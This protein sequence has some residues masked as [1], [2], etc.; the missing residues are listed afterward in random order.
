MDSRNEIDS[1]LGLPAH[2]IWSYLSGGW[3]PFV[4]DV[5]HGLFAF[6]TRE[7]QA[8]LYE[9]L[10]HDAVLELGDPQGESALYKKRQRVKFLQDH[11]IA[12]QDFAWGDG[13]VLADYRCSPGVVVDRYKN[14]D[15]WNVLISLR[16]TKSR[17]D[18]EDFHIQRRIIRGFTKNEEWW[19]LEMQHETRWLKLSIIFPKRRPCQRAVLFEKTRNR[20]TVLNSESLA[21]LPDG[22]Q[23]LTW[24]KTRPKRF[25]TYTIKWCW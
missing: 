21:N 8:G 25:E 17:G 13:R 20:V 7:R 24:E 15:R 9:M 3:L 22:R 4:L 19:Q 6:L 18:N 12:F 1:Q 5:V 16:E 14:G 23:V 11:V 2:R 10:E